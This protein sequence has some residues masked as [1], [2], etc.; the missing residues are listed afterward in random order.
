L[1]SESQWE[2]VAKIDNNIS[3]IGSKYAWKIYTDT[4]AV[5]TK[6]PNKFGIYD[7][8]GNVSEIVSDSIHKTYNNAPIDGSSWYEYGSKGM[9]VRECLNGKSYNREF[10]Y[11]KGNHIGF[12]I[13]S[14]RKNDIKQKKEKKSTKSIKKESI[15]NIDLN[16]DTNSKIYLKNSKYTQPVDMQ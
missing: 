12:R 14:I 5:G 3:S 15:D 7:L 10:K 1:P 2:Y 8:C 9:I 13:L 16:N 4:H 11:R 6:L